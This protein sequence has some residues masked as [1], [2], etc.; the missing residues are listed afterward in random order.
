MK[1]SEVPKIEP[2]VVAEQELLGILMNNPGRIEEVSA[3]L[4]P[5]DFYLEKHRKVYAAMIDLWI[6]SEPITY[7]SLYNILHEEFL[8]SDLV[9]TMDGYL[10]DTHA[11]ELATQIRKEAVMRRLLATLREIPE[12]LQSGEMKPDDVEQAVE[13]TLN[14]LR[15]ATAYETSSQVYGKLVN[16]AQKPT[17]GLKTGFSSLDH[18]IGGYY[19]GDFIV[20]AGRTTLGKTA[21]AID[22]T[23]HQLKEKKSV[24]FLSCEMMPNDIMARVISNYSGMD[25]FKFRRGLTE[26][27]LSDLKTMEEEISVL[28]LLI[29]KESDVSRILGI[30]R[31]VK[32]K[33]GLQFMVI[34]YLQL[35]TSSSIL[36]NRSQFIGFITREI[37]GLALELEI[38]VL[39]LCQ[40]SRD[41]EKEGRLPRLSDLRDSGEIEQTA[42]VVMFLCEEIFFSRR[43][44][45]ME[46]EL[47]K[48][49]SDTRFLIVGKSRFGASKRY[50]KMR[51]EGAKMKFYEITEE[52]PDLPAED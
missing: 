30:C 21:F 32:R 38:P 5:D 26:Q 7:V 35:L 8:V 9:E 47:E 4:T 40:F 24:L 23:G 25:S 42:D 14:P 12:K 16:Q 43:K 46:E 19:P 50:I 48:A 3:G 22:T 27:E 18:I 33:Y 36:E 17:M 11:G 41:V 31:Q 49:K 1:K 45:T 15:P 44:K 37:K 34:D 20:L 2:I 13:R 51:Y 39:V 28:P 10:T 52:Y 29:A 6:K